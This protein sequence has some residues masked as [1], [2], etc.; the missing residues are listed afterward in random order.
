MVFIYRILTILL[1]PPLYVFSFII[2]AAREFLRI[3]SDDKKKILAA[4]LPGSNQRVVWLHAASVGELD[5]CKALAVVFREKEPETLILQSVFSPSVRESQLDAFPAHVKFHLPLDFPWAYAFIFEKFHPELLI[6]MAWDR[7]PNLLLEARRRGALTILASAVLTPPE[8]FFKERFYRS[9]FG[10]FDRIFPSHT[11]A[12]QSFRNLLGSSAKIKTLGDCRIDTVIRKVESN[13][14]R[15]ERPENYPFSKIFL[16]AS[17]YEECENLLLPLLS[18]PSLQDF[19]FWIFPHKTDS[20]RI[21]S[22]LGQVKKRTEN[23]CLFS[24]KPFEKIDSRVII[25][26]VLGLLA[27]AYQVV[28]FAYVGGA[29]HNRV[30]N[31]LEPAYFGLPLLTGPR[32][33]HSPE[34]KELNRHGGLFIIR[35]RED[36]IPILSLSEE[37]KTE[38]AETNR[39]FLETGRGA[40]DRIYRALRD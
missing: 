37:K 19:A 9:V 4:S 38:I 21:Q 11:S 12:E 34:A 28:D 33:D 22:V 14:R 3:R 15:F 5:Q 36:V 2:P 35:N 27:Y 8:G 40:G 16:L 23:Y 10:L 31:V 24:S 32:I 25:F 7:W 30:H 26:D 18:E 13:P 17:T 39:S 6:L 29:L 20:S 1:W